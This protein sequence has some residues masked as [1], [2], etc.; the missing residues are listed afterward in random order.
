MNSA[1]FRVIDANMNRAREGLRVAEDISRFILEDVA[2]TKSLKD[3]RHKLW[4][5]YKDLFSKYEVIL[6]RDVSHD[7][8]REDPQDS[9]YRKSF[10]DV[11][12]A[13][14]QRA[15]E[16]LRV[17]EEAAKLL[18]SKAFEEFKALRFTLYDEEKKAY[19]TFKTARKNENV[20]RRRKK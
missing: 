11:F 14:I 16:A 4:L 15:K 17:L 18:N 19:Q 3:L 6:G 13:N 10:E 5:V 2:M 20:N 12:F 8:G 9:K 7:I 1:I